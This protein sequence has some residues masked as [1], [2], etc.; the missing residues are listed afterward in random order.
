MRDA[1]KPSRDEASRCSDDVM[2]GG[3]ARRRRS[4][5]STERTLYEALRS[6]LATSVANASAKYFRYSVTPVKAGAH[7]LL[8]YNLNQSGAPVNLFAPEN[9]TKAQ[10]AGIFSEGRLIFENKKRSKQKNHPTFRKLLSVNVY[11]F[12]VL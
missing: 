10:E 6:V 4:R 3:G 9:R 11:L 7:L 8:Q 2:Y 5:F 1:A 12:H